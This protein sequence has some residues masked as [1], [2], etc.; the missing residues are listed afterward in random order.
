MGSTPCTTLP[1]YK[2]T[3]CRVHLIPLGAGAEFRLRNPSCVS[4]KS[5]D[6]T[7]ATSGESPLK[8]GSDPPT[9]VLKAMP[10]NPSSTACLAAARVPECHMLLPRFGPMLMPDNTT[11][12]CDQR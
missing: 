11:S 10:L 3:D 6:R 8:S 4:C 2:R 9:G 1:S 7:F 5:H 12:I